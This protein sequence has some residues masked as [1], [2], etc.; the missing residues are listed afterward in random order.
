M[1]KF[2][3]ADYVFSVMHQSFE[4]PRTPPTIIGGHPGQTGG[5]HLVFSWFRFSDSQGMH[6]FSQWLS[7]LYN[8]EAEWGF[9]RDF[10]CGSQAPLQDWVQ[11]ASC[12]LQLTKEI[13]CKSKLWLDF[14]NMKIVPHKSSLE[15]REVHSEIF[16]PCPSL[17][18]TDSKSEFPGHLPMVGCRS[19]K[20]LVHYCAVFCAL[21]FSMF[22]HKHHSNCIYKCKLQNDSPPGFRL[23]IL[24]IK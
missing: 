13:W 15:C 16:F 22:T 18:F 10:T 19:F 2:C 6:L 17:H 21:S 8:A 7:V 14:I 23:M 4:T 9:G 1:I 5:F 20:W 11:V 24:S 3:S 12:K